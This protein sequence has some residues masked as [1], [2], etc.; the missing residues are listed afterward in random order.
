MRNILL[1][2]GLLGDFM[3]IATIA[4][5][6]VKNYSEAQEYQLYATDEGWVLQLDAAGLERSDILIDVEDGQLEVSSQHA[7]YGFKKSFG[8]GEDVDVENISAKLTQGVLHL[9]LPKTVVQK[10]QINID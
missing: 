1:N 7:E 4:L 10:K 5:E 9:T 3:K 6:E 8:I 2:H